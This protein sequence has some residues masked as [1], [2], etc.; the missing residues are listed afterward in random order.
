MLQWLGDL[1]DYLDRNGVTGPSP[2]PRTVEVLED[3]F[4]VYSGIVTVSE[5]SVLVDIPD[6][7]LCLSL[8]SDVTT[9]EVWKGSVDV[10]VDSPCRDFGYTFVLLNYQVSVIKVYPNPFHEFESHRVKGVDIFPLFSS[11]IGESQAHS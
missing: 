6:P 11:W 7:S 9:Y 10:L 8:G 2:E 1:P 4:P 3:K 5:R